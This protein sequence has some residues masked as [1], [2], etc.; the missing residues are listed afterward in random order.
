VRSANLALLAWDPP[1]C[2]IAVKKDCRSITL[3]A[4]GSTPGARPITRY[5]WTIGDE[6]KDTGEPVLQ[7]LREPSLCPPGQACRIEIAVQVVDQVG[8]RSQRCAQSI[9]LPPCPP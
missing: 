3:D 1:T 7:Q 8:Q 6:R 5:L 9:E 2:R 4:G